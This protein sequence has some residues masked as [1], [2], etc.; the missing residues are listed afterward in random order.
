[1]DKETY[2]LKL[3]GFYIIIAFDWTTPVYSIYNISGMVTIEN[4]EKIKSK[5][6]TEFNVKIFKTIK[7]F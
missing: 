5:L 3:S 1:M 4:F 6:S 2:Y 7:T